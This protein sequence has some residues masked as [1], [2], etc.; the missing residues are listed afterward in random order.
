MTTQQIRRIRAK[1]N[2]YK[3]QVM[4]AAASEDHV[5]EAMLAFYAGAAALFAIQNDEIAMLPDMIAVHAMAGIN[6]ELAEFAKH[7]A[8]HGEVPL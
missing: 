7:Y 4:P 8:T 5:R 3:K 1:W 2:T 6:N